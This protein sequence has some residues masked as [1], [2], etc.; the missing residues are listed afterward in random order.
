MGRC[1]PFFFQVV[2]GDAEQR[3]LPVDDT[4]VGEVGG[5]HHGGGAGEAARTHLEEPQLAALPGELQVAGVAVVRFDA[6]HRP[7]QTGP[8]PGLPVGQGAQG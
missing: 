5:D 6:G 3:L 7:R 8:H 1:G 4:G 2:R